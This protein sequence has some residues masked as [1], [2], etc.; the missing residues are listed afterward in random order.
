MP[1]IR[2]YEDP[3]GIFPDSDLGGTLN[4]PG[5]YGIPGLPIPVSARLLPGGGDPGAGFPVEWLNTSSDAPFPRSLGLGGYAGLAGVPGGMGDASQ[6]AI[7]AN[8]EG[9]AKLLESVDPTSAARL[10]AEADQV[11]LSATRSDPSYYTAQTQLPTSSDGGIF[12]SFFDSDPSGSVGAEVTSSSGSSGGW[13]DT[14]T[15][16]FS[17]SVPGSVGAEV[18]G[19]TDRWDRR[20]GDPDY[21]N[22]TA[23]A[24]LANM[25]AGDA[26]R[27]RL[28]QAPTSGGWYQGS[29]DYVAPAP[30]SGGGITEAI[31]S[32]F[33]P[34][35]TGMTAQVPGSSG[36]AVSAGLYAPQQRYAQAP[37]NQ[38]QP[39]AS[40]LETVL[41]IAA[42]AGGTTLF[43]LVLWKVLS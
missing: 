34:T 1:S 24:I 18:T 11:R 10:Y 27:A 15:S 26:M 14:I 6:D 5:V 20:P 23:P 2:P 12:S 35:P 42:V 33:T 19:R 38:A 4:A 21:G 41:P 37:W 29:R 9:Q 25:R 30:S 8:L 43:G 17:N 13:F 36:F 32:V 3:F 28:T 16:M 22:S 31:R 39:K 40:A 7:V